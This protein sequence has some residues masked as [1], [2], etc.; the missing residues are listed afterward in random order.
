MTTAKPYRM[1]VF[2][3]TGKPIFDFKD[4]DPEELI[5]KADKAFKDKFA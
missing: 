2:E 3:E 1:K 5:K 4:K